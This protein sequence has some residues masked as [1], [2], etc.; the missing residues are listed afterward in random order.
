M[1]FG[2][3]PEGM[4]LSETAVDL[5][6]LELLVKHGIAFTILSPFQ[7]QKIRRVGSADWIDVKGGMI[8][9][10]RPYI[11]TLP[12]GTSIYL[13]FYNGNISRAIAFES[14]LGSGDNLLQRVLAEF[15]PTADEEPQL[16][17]VATDGESY[18]HHHRFGDMALAYMINRVKKSGQAYLTNYG[19]FLARSAVTYEVR[20]KENTA[21]S[22]AHGVERWKSNCG[23]GAD[24]QTGTNQKWRKPL[25]NTL[26]WLRDELDEIFEREGRKYFTDPWTARNNFGSLLSNRDVHGVEEFMKSHMAGS[27]P[28]EEQIRAL[29][30]LEMERY[31]QYMFTSCAWFFT[32]ISGIETVQI[33]QYAYRAIDLAEEF[34]D[35]EFKRRFYSEITVCEE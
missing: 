32:D 10:R 22:C 26:N 3:E 1:R 8:D 9:S 12:S 28:L 23:C 21:W 5:T 18:G 11:C 19:A 13:F 15:T 6:T 35:T 29:R 16:V 7:A 4:W 17:N 2:R 24:L 30:L 33:L 20:I 31:V 25:R 34:F 27:F 14:L